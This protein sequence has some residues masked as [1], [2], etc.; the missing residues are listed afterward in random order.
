MFSKAPV[1]V[2]VLVQ[3]GVTIAAI[4][5]VV[6]GLLV[7]A[8]TYECHTWKDTGVRTRMRA[9]SCQVEVSPGRW[10]PSHRWT[11]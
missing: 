5:V 4:G 8:G 9:L 6:A 10:V 3:I 1:V 11:R 2:R 7:A